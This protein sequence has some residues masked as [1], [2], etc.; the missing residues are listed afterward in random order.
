MH[1]FNSM[2]S[3]IKYCIYFGTLSVYQ[4][5]GYCRNLHSKLMYTIHVHHT[6]CQIV[7][8]FM[9]PQLMNTTFHKKCRPIKTP[10]QC[11][12]LLILYQYACSTDQH[13]LMISVQTYDTPL[14]SD[15]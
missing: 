11:S 2:A 3:A 13:R 5:Y 8:L 6:N 15:G 9:V 12:L 7:T 1:N 14:A 10:F 4:R